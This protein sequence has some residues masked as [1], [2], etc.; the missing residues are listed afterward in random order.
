MYYVYLLRSKPSPEQTYIGYS[1]NLKSRLRA[2]NN[3][4]SPHTSKYKPWQ[5]VT[6]LAFKERQTAIDFEKYLKS[7]SGIAFARK[8]LW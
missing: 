5:L 8:R 4:Q 6:Y 3:G 1:E 7:H 2:H